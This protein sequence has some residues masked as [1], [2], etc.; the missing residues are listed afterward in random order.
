MEVAD[1]SNPEAVRMVGAV[2]FKNFIS[3]KGA[4]HFQHDHNP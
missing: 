4:V 3:N 1:D 2:V